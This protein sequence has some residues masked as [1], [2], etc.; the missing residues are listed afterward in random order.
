MVRV[1]PMRKAR[2]LDNQS[3]DPF[4]CSIFRG[5]DENSVCEKKLSSHQH[6][7]LGTNG[8]KIMRLSALLITFLICGPLGIAKA[9]QIA[10][11][12]VESV[13]GGHSFGELSSVEFSP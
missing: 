9:Q 5:Y 1:L 8:P 13:L 6:P 4:L 10:A 3:R 11:L 12:P 7:R 2:Y